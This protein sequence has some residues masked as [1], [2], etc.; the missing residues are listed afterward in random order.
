[1]IAALVTFETNGKLSLEDA[2]EKF[3]T[4][5]PNYR[6][7]DGL[8]AKSYIYREDGAV[9]G[10]FYLWET[11]EAAEAQYSP[12]WQARAE[13]IY[14]VPPV[15]QYFEVPVHIQNAAAVAPAD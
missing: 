4:T 12:E 6:G 3:N 11:K 2:I 7:K 8:I 9:L 13:E 10:G 14:G 15:I 1:M 5:A